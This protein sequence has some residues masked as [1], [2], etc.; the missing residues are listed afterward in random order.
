MR[1][2]KN[3]EPPDLY[4]LDLAE[5][6]VRQLTSTPWEEWRPAVAPDHSVFFIA[7]PNAQFD[8]YR[9]GSGSPASLAV[10]SPVDE[11]DPAVSPDGEWL[12]YASRRRGNW[13]LFLTHLK[14]EALPSIQ[15]TSGP[16][17][18]WDPSWHPSG[19][20]ILFAGTDGGSSSQL[21][22]LCPFGIR[23]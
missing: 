10:E 14:N 11:W 3:R 17:D 15:L 5:G 22:A 6:A 12:A 16:G 23:E 8:I 13:D 20:A 18:E 21:M 19:R 4:A 9:L 2:V 1:G 7:D